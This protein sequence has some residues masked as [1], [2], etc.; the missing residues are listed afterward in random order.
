MHT[1]AK[2]LQIIRVVAIYTH[3]NINE[4]TKYIPDNSGIFVIIDKHLSPYFLFH[5]LPLIKVTATEQNKSL[6]TVAYITDRLLKLGADRDC[7]IIGVGG[8]VTTDLAGFVASIYKRGV[9]FGFVPT[10]F[11]SCRPMPHSGAKT[12]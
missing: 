9:R 10:N 7:F 11:S 3:K 5:G 2:Q 1:F 6:E 4:L 12:E 8:G